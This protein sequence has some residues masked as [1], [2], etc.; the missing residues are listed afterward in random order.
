VGA[1]SG[2]DFD[3]CLAATE[4]KRAVCALVHDSRTTV[5]CTAVT[6]TYSK[7][8]CQHVATSIQCT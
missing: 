3:G 7:Y 2:K 5:F 6:G 4:K 8:G 1:P